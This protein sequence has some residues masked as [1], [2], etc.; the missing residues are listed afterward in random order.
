MND[1]CLV[2]LK[3]AAAY[4]GVST[5]TV[6]RR[7]RDGSLAGRKVG[8]EHRFEPQI[9]RDFDLSPRQVPPVPDDDF[10]AALSSLKYDDV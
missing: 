10:R 9:L 7:V 1:E 6:T 5:K 3:Q 4:L 2:D 8:R